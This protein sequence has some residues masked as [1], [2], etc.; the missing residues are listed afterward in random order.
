MVSCYKA[1]LLVCVKVHTPGM[2]HGSCGHRSRCTILL[3]C[4]DPFLVPLAQTF[5]S[6]SSLAVQFP[7]LN[8]L[9]PYGVEGGPL[10]TRLVHE[11]L[12]GLM[13][14]LNHMALNTRCWRDCWMT[15][16]FGLEPTGRAVAR[17]FA[18]TRSSAAD[19]RQVVLLSQMGLPS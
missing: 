2:S 10:C 6:G 8:S 15:G 18:Y 19:F 7:L 4:R 9:W 17:R 1:T 14:P 11:G 13:V 12:Y 16:T 3:T 5:C